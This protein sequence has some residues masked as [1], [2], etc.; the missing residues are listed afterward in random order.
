MACVKRRRGRW[1][2]DF[3]DQ[4]GARRWESYRTRD[5]AQA[6]LAVRIKELRT[7][8]YRPPTE[9]PVFETVARAWL[10]TKVEYR[11]SSYSQWQGHIDLHILPVLGALRIDQIRVAHI[12]ALRDSCRRAGL[13]PKTV[14]KVLTT[15]AA[16]FKFAIRREYTDR[17][18]AAMAE[19]CRLR[20]EP[21]ATTD[22]SSLAAID[23][24]AVLSPDEARRLIEAA[25]PGLHQTF[26]LTAVLTGARIGELTALQW[27]DVGFEKRTL[28][29]RRSVTF[30]RARGSTGKVKPQ[31]LPPKTKAG[32][33][34]FTIPAE[35]VSALRRWKLQCPIKSELIFPKRDGEP[36]HRTTLTYEVFR[37]ALARAG[38]RQVTFHSLRHSCASALLLAGVPDVEVAHILG[39]RDTTVTRAIY[40]HW[41]RDQK[42]TALERLATAVFGG[43]PAAKPDKS[44]SKMVAVGSTENGLVR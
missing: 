39:H 23:P 34:T 31:I 9:V 25:E 30:A 40:T 33:R 35:L 21:G 12:D 26:L 37:P 3:R 38:L 8:N 7:G 17:N 41:F 29:I 16:I 28:S 13:A 43:E 5:E 6:A 24:S 42:S 19:R 27:S 10:A 20:A 15:V 18:P 44:G 36:Y 11:P 22:P 1:V 14:N 2:V 4:T 32:N